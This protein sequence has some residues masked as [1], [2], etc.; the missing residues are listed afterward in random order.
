MKLLRLMPVCFL[1]LCVSCFAQA[2][3]PVQ[4][5]GPY[6]RL[7]KV[8]FVLR[9]TQWISTES[10]KV[11]MSIDANVQQEA[12]ESLQPSVLKTLQQ[13]APN[14]KWRITDYNRSQDQSGLERVTIAAQARLTDKDLASLRANAKKQSQPG[15]KYSIASIS[16]VP[17]PGEVE[18]ARNDLRQKLYARIQDEI[19]Q[20]QSVYPEQHF[21]VHKISFADGDTPPMPRNTKM[22]ATMSAAPEVSQPP[23]D[24][25]DQLKMSVNVVLASTI[26]VN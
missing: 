11:I 2:P 13:M 15:L 21:Y 18:Q 22:Y 16:Y 1:F 20:L 24:V 14:A 5:V 17:T 8:Q 3:A 4:E 19:K 7:N 23:M 6:P 10:A 25:S 26:K 12:L 9:D